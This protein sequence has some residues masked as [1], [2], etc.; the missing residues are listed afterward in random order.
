M[1]CWDLG[2]VPGVWGWVQDGLQSQ[3]EAQE[4]RAPGLTLPGR[5]LGRA[6]WGWKGRECL[7]HLPPQG[8]RGSCEGRDRVGGEGR[9]EGWTERTVG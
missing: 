9:R 7:T 1:L 3:Q 4:G 6:A 2:R 8:P 5:L